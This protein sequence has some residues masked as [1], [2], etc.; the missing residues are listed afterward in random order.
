MIALRWKAK[1]EGDFGLSDALRD[2]LDQ[3]GIDVKD[4]PSSSTWSIRG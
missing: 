1:S 4:E 2:A 3:S